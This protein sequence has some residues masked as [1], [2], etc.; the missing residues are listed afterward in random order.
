MKTAHPGL[1]RSG[2]GTLHIPEGTV[3]GEFVTIRGETWYRI[4][5][6]DLI[7]PFFMSVVSGSDHWLFVSSTGGLTAGRGNADRALF[8]YYTDDRVAENHANTGPVAVF[9]VERGAERYL[10]EPFA[11]LGAGPYRT[12]RNLYKNELCSALCFEERNIDLGLT[13]RYAWRTGDQFGFVKTSVLANE[14]SGELSVTLLDGLRNILPPFVEAQTQSAFSNL[15]DAYKRNELESGTGIGVF[16]LSSRL[17]D[18]A[19]PSEALLATV[20]WQCGLDNPVYLLSETQLQAFRAGVRPV[21]ETDLRGKRGAYLVCSEVTLPPGAERR[22]DIAADIYRDA[23]EV[24]ALRRMM[25]SGAP[26]MREALER[27]ISA[28]DAALRSVIAAADGLSYTADRPASVH[29]LANVLFNTMR[30]GYF[31]D[32]GIVGKADLI[33]FIGGRNRVTASRYAAFFSELPERFTRRELLARA[34]ET[35]SADLVRLCSEYLPLSFSRR[36]GDP[37]RPWNRFSIDVKHPD[38]S[39]RLEYQGNWRDIFQNW[40]ALSLSY[41]EY[42]EAMIC[43]FL[44]ATTAD[45]YNP[46]RISREGIE[47]ETPDPDNPW[48]NIGYWGDHQIVY[49]SRLL[50]LSRKFYPGRLE[51][52]LPERRF[53]HAEVPYRIREYRRMI[54]NPHDTIEFDHELDRRIGLRVR[55]IGADGKLVTGR[56]GSVFHVT[57]LE[58][59][60]ILLLAKLVNFVPDGG[61]WLNTQRP[62]WNDANNAL[63]GPGVS[64]VT[65]AYLVRFIGLFESLVRSCDGSPFR[66]TDETL[67]LFGSMGNILE[68]FAGRLS[69]SGFDDRSRRGMM[70]ELGTA[71]S[72]YRM[73]LYRNGF[74]GTFEPL[75]TDRLLGFLALARSFAEHALSANRRPDALYHA[76]NTLRFG[77]DTVTLRRLPEMLEGQVAALSSGTL[78]AAGALALLESLRKSRLYRADRHSYILYPDRDLPGFLEKNRIPADRAGRIPLVR[79]LVEDSDRSIVIRDQDGTYRFSGAF[80]NAEDVRRALDALAC[81]TRYAELAARDRDAV[82]ELFELTF[83]HASFTGRSGTFFAYEGLGSIYWHMVSKL[84]LAAQE[85][86]F[87]AREAG[88]PAETLEALAARYRD[89]RRGLGFNA[90]PA[91][92]GAFPTDPYSHT[93]A[94]SGARQ[95]GMTGQVKEEILTRFRELGVTVER[96]TLSFDPVLLD[97][98]EFG[99]TAGEFRYLDTSGAERVIELQPGSLAFTFCGVPVVYRTSQRRFLRIETADGRET[100]LEGTS[101]DRELSSRIFSRDGFVSLIELHGP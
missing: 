79:R 93:P 86:F 74:S 4:G 2:I 18:R 72:R 60:L 29:H 92:F 91:E 36:H 71:G 20:V 1:I 16:S 57:M 73:N 40:E 7:P 5:R 52:L 39:R 83:D 84:L 65:L 24:V 15:L 98:V 78:S 85:T 68:R 17:T 42:M 22:W 95:P 58:K 6:Y 100:A 101:L 50:E 46:Y 94:G 77:P 75:E 21:R 99:K 90:S 3:A 32:N 23:S 8:P 66:V 96:G 12:E 49:L 48:S 41:P 62:E 69:G 88:E 26:A 59:L 44:D 25:E 67:G 30:G 81:G 87:R 45:G 51:A 27:D 54:E 9:L 35:G 13:Y 70:D 43:V 80:R 33:R 10:W 38:G 28:N 47:W 63:A 31:P 14:S 37:S 55:E 64:V 53:S 56:D 11:S 97:P 89:I 19:E 82:L 76:Y 34:E 61:I